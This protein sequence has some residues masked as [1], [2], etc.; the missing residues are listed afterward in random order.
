M[1]L[2]LQLGKVGQTG[3]AAGPHLHFGYIPKGSTFADNVY[4]DP[5]PCLFET[6]SGRPGM[7]FK[8]TANGC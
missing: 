4:V 3:V 7:P 1:H 6:A 8:N 5:Y 2:D